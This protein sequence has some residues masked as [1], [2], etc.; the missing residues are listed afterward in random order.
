MTT[1][2]ELKDLLKQPP[3]IPIEWQI[4]AAMNVTEESMQAAKDAQKYQYRERIPEHLLRYTDLYNELTGQEPTKQTLSDWIDTAETWKDEQF[5][6]ESLREAWNYSLDDKHGFP[7]GRPGALTVTAR[8]MKSKGK[9]P[10]AAI[11]EKRIQDTK[12]M[13]DELWQRPFVPRPANVAPPR[14]SRP[15]FKKGQEP[16]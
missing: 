11:N 1:T 13:V 15:L 6:M 7:V 9:A 3:A 10:R 12:Q 16:K 2:T 5:T 4:A 8:S 14:I